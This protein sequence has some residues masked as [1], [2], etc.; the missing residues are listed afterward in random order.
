[1]DNTAPTTTAS[2]VDD[3]SAAYTFGTWTSSSYVNVTLSATDG[4][5]GTDTTLYCTDTAN[6]CT[7]ST[8]Y[9]SAVQISTEGTSYIRYLTN[10]TV[11]NT[12]AVN[13]QTIQIDTT[14]PVANIT[15]IP[16]SWQNTN[17]TITFSAYDSGAGVDTTWYNLSSSATCPAFDTTNYTAYSASFNVTS[18]LTLCW[19]VN[20]TVGNANTTAGSSGTYIMVDQ[21]APTVALPSVTLSY[22]ANGTVYLPATVNITAAVLDTG[23]SGINFSSCQFSVDNGT[24]FVPGSYASGSCLINGISTNTSGPWYIVVQVL[25]NATN[26]N[27]NT[28]YIY[29]Q[30]ASA[31]SVNFTQPSASGNCYTCSVFP[32]NVTG[33]VGDAGSGVQYVNV[34]T[35]NGLWD[36]T[37]VS[38]NTW[39]YTWPTCPSDGTYYLLVQATDN[40]NQANTTYAQGV[41]NMTFGVDNSTPDIAVAYPTA[42][43]TQQ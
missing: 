18:N 25:D 29:T 10:D 39:N 27:T 8:V 43:N 40:L 22:N 3:T 9:S 1:V 31:P 19:Y 38:G 41:A 17:A 33:A 24:N 34:S 14:P 11:G 13:S 28:N 4:G 5:S 26:Q 2:A 37:N 35:A 30:D 6:T 15:D 21:I 32:F 20:D 36:T 7:P 16:P 23:G 42:N 12:E